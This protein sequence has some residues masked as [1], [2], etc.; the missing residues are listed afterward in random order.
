[1]TNDRPH[2]F[3]ASYHLL[4]ALVSAAGLLLLTAGA[5]PASAASGPHPKAARLPRA[6]ATAAASDTRAEHA[7]IGKVDQ[8]RAC[9]RHQHGHANACESA[10]H[11]LEQAGNRL[12]GAERRL[13]NVAGA[14]RHVAHSSR[15]SYTAQAPTL[16]VSGQ[17]LDWT[18]VY[19]VSDYLL[20]REVPGQP[21]RDSLVEGTSTTPPP[22]PGVT[23]RYAVRTAVYGSAWSHEVSITYPAAV[24]KP[25]ETTPPPKSESPSTTTPSEPPATSTPSET[26]DTQAAP[27]VT[28]SGQ[29]LSWNAVGNVTTYILD[30][31]TA[32]A[33]N[34]YTEVSGTSVTPTA[35]PG[36]T[37]AYQVRT[38]VEGSA[39]STAV[40]ISYPAPEPP[41]AS[42]E[43]APET[44]TFE[45]GLNS[46]TNM[47]LD[48]N[49]SVDLGAKLVRIA[50]ESDTTP[51]QMEP[52]I[53]GYAA[54]GIRVLPLFSFYGSMPSSTEARDL[55]NW[56]K[57]YG[58][59]GSYWSSHSVNSE[60]IEAIEFGNE[61]SYS[62]QY[63]GEEPTSPAYTARAE[64]YADRFKEA[65]E[66]ISAT[67]IK[68]GLL[69]QADNTSGNWVKDMFHAV[70]NL[71]SY[72]AG[73]TIHPYGPTWKARLQDLINQ[74]S[75]AGASSSIPIDITEWGL[76][77]DNGRCLSENYGWNR[78][79]SYSEAASTLTSAVAEMRTMLGSRL[80]MFMLYAVRDEAATGASTEREA[81]F[82]ALQHELQ[83]K[84]AYTTAV[85]ALLA[86]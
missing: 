81:Y 70:P 4:L 21:V 63:G 46:G 35:V 34:Q 59:G 10:R 31:Y 11:A 17:T 3:R 43:P 33:G 8:L 19:G 29:T 6:I 48:V 49:G 9:L 71:G 7:L 42:K 62:Y 61:T 36:Q 27:T 57:A 66:A 82:G 28:V 38:A 79:M 72:V 86:S 84:G 67:G 30:T 50:F 64:T 2:S 73:W 14:P 76:T 51:A 80:H 22:V 15:Y 47:T 75:A 60:P 74:T 26:V 16:T 41:P 13:A 58:P 39:W 69:A 68:V 54:K 5:V 25:T 53:A 32:S 18:H 52:V 20:M 23:V 65:A 1:M 77:S 45:P 55:A 12:A 24:S 78:C 44:S 85:Q 37:V 40:S 83:P 56:A